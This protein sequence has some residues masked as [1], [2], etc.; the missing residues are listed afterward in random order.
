MSNY[1]N[2]P[3]TLCAVIFGSI[4]NLLTIYVLSVKSVHR[5]RATSIYNSPLAPPK[6]FSNSVLQSERCSVDISAQRRRQTRSHSSIGVSNRPRVYTFFVWL[7]I[8]DTF[9]LLSALLMYAVPSLMNGKL[10]HYVRL[11]PYFYLMSNSALTASVWLMC[12]LVFDRYRTLSSPF[13]IRSSNVSLVHRV[14]LSICMIALIFSLPRFFELHLVTDKESGIEYVTQTELVHNQLYMV[15]YRIVGG[16]MLYSLLPYVI[17]FILS[18]KVWLVIRA[19]ALARMKM[20]ASTTTAPTNSLA[21]YVCATDSEMILIAVT[22]KFLLSR[23]I[24][25]MLDVVEHTV[26]PAQFTRSS[27]LTICVD[28]SNL[29]VVTASSINLLIFYVFSKSFRASLITL[30]SNT[31][32]R[33]ITSPLSNLSTVTM[34][35]NGREKFGGPPRQ[36]PRQLS[37]QTDRR[38]RPGELKRKTTV[39]GIPLSNSTRGVR[40][41]PL[42]GGPNQ[43]AALLRMPTVEDADVQRLSPGDQIV[44]DAVSLP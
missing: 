11:F 21:L 13:A 19:A 43:T 6:K 35:T 39:G 33:P 36:L 1:L 25:T 5:H 42:A 23:L 29:I 15:G 9:L 7:A 41:S 17:L 18:F 30:L 28:I 38:R 27:T 44:K 20:N 3:V 40:C 14:L 34:A 31:R 12:S 8:S 32:S 24:P 26:G 37:L 2:G 16:L 22:S 10:G 4:A